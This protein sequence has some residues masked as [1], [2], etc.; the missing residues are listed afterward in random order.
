MA[1]REQRE[2]KLDEALDRMLA[3]GIPRLER[4]WVDLLSTAI[5]AGVEVGFGVIAYLVVEHATGSQPLAGVAFSVGFIAL[6][7]GHSELFTE[8]FLVPVTVLVAKKAKPRQLARFWVGTLIGNL[9]GGAIVAWLIAHAFPELSTTMNETA[10]TYVNAGLH[11]RTLCL[12]VLAGGAITLLTRM[13]HGTDSDVAKVLSSIALAFV[14]AGTGLFHSV[15]DSVF[16]F[17]ALS[18]GHAPFGYLDW[19]GWVWWVVLANMV[20][21]LLLTTLL[22]LVRSRG[23]IQEKREEA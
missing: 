16:A 12:A 4:G 20:G 13:H 9:I 2:E 14:L 18:T 3:E 21:G 17:T 10:S 19:L 23:A 8:G 22:R 15:L 7:L 5:V 1:Q 11:T 6:L